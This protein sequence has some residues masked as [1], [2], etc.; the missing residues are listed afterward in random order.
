MSAKPT[1]IPVILVGG[2]GTRL[3]SVVPDVPKP[4][5]IVKDRPFIHYLFD[6]LLDSGFT[7]VILC[8]GYKAKQNRQS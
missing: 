5:A 6:Q 3:K 4:L 8:T 1:I 2:R 7:K